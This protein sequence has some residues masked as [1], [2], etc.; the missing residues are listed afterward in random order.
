M[1]RVMAWLLVSKILLLLPLGRWCDLVIM[2]G[3]SLS[4]LHRRLAASIYLLVVRCLVDLV[5]LLLLWPL[6]RSI[7]CRKAVP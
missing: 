1:R 5:Y 6:R 2:L 4:L 3:D 7:L